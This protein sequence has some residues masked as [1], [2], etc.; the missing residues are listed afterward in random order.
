MTVETYLD[1]ARTRVQA[2]QDAV[3][4][5]LDAYD[6]FIRQ[7]TDLQ[8]DPTPTPTAGLT[9]TGGTQLTVDPP[10]DDQCG[11][12][13]TVFAETVRPHSVATF[14][15]PE[16]LLETLREEFTDAVAVALAPTTE[17]SFT[18]DLKRMVT[19]EA[20][21]RR[22]EASA[23]RRTLDRE[24]GH[25]EEAGTAVDEITAWIADA[26]ETPLTQ[27][28]FDALAG[29]HDTLATHRDRC[30]ELARH[31]QEFLQ[32]ATNAGIEIGVRHR[33]LVP[34][35]YRDFPIDHPVLATV[36]TLDDT[37]AAC[38]RAVRVHLVRR[39]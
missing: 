37:C 16:S 31:R 1:R 14:D 18:P 11:T 32:Q 30:T 25:L 15:E 29:R 27:L 28:G 7:V 13:R 24:T 2:E 26:D 3:D 10:T 9:T 38:Q 8:P 36:A 33:S 20:Q 21:S 12:V 39:A 5:K 17:A 35:L 34:Y 19:T 6:A 22:S 23:L 4:A